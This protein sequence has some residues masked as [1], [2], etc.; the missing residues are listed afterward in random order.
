MREDEN[1]AVG[2]VLRCSL[3]R[4][5]G[6]TV[7]RFIPLV[8]L[9][10]GRRVVVLLPVFGLCPLAADELVECPSTHNITSN[11]PDLFS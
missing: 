5:E 2:R 10:A 1:P 4:R 3:F 6:L 8:F 7:R 9:M 11:L